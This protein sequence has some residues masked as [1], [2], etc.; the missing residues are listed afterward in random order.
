MN[1]VLVAFVKLPKGSE[2]KA[3]TVQMPQTCADNLGNAI[4]FP[5]EDGGEWFAVP[6]GVVGPASDQSG[7]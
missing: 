2:L 7:S 4:R 6:G 3:D 1:M 5:D